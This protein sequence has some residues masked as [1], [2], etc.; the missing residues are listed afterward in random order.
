[1]AYQTILLIEDSDDLRL[2]LGALLNDAG[3]KVLLASD[4]LSAIGHLTSN[5]EIDVIVTDYRIPS[6][7]GGTW[8]KFL[9]KFFRPEIKLGVMSAYPI[10]PKGLPFLRKPFSYEEFLNFVEDVADDL[11][12]EF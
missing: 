1:M 11:A 9:A 3:Y 6:I 7:D 10:D 5:A 12:H 4:S 8:V 2:C